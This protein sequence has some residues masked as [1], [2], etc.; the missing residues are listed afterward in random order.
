MSINW[1]IDKQ[2]AGYSNNGILFKKWSS[3]ICYNIDELSSIMFSERS[4]TQE[5]TH[6]TIPFT[7]YIPASQIHRH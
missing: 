3:D 4:Q 5:T 7:G 1:W 2:N 6:G